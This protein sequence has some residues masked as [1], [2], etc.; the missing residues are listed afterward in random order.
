MKE[1]L[2][3]SDGVLVYDFTHKAVKNINLRIKR[4]GS[5]HVSAPRTV[6]IY[7][8]ETFLRQKETFIRA[9]QRKFAA[10]PEISSEPA[11]LA[12]GSVF[13]ILGEPKTI[14]ILPAHLHESVT[15]SEKELTVCVRPNQKAGHVRYLL[16]SYIKHAFSEQIHQ[17][18]QEI[19][20]RFVAVKPDLVFP[21]I[22]VR[23]MSSRYGS[24]N[25]SKHAVTVNTLLYLCPPHLTEYVA[26]HEFTHFFVQNH[27]PEFYACFARFFPDWKKCKRELTEFALQNHIFKL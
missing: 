7:E 27:S 24:C 1:S 23:R 5:V 11:V 6:N 17:I 4:D 12:D 10:L 15:V 21:D 26:C 14:R 2:L 18:C 25:A 13:P 19:F 8:V 16:E 20:P 9:A 22:K 3:L